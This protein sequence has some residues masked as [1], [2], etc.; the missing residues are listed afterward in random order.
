MDKFHGI[1][2]AVQHAQRQRDGLAELHL[3]AQRNLADG[4]AQ[5][6]QLRLYAQD[7]ETR[8]VGAGTAAYGAEVMRHYHQFGAKLQQAIGMQADVIRGLEL[9]VS[10]AQAALLQ[11]EFRL[12]AIQK[13]LATR[14]QQ[15]QHLQDRRDQANTDELATQAFLRKQRSSMISG[16]PKNGT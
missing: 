1:T 5:L 7:I 12:A 2:L 6:E 8:W 11:G 3:Q 10:Q 13:L 9:S 15:S 14:M 4:Q 16:V